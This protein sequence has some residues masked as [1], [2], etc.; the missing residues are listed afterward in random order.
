MSFTMKLRAFPAIIAAVLSASCSPSLTELAADFSAASGSLQSP[1]GAIL[2]AKGDSI[3]VQIAFGLADIEERSANTVATNF[4][5]ASVTKQFTAM[6]ILILRDRGSLRL[7]QPLADFFP[8]FAPIGREITI[9]Q[10]LTHT[11]GLVAYE[12]VMPD[13][14]TIPLLDR[15]VL[16]LVQGIHYLFT[17]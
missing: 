1:G 12:E 9:R 3:L 11:S 16:N 10:L 15:D 7:D 17:A 13:T 8:D 14:T 4:R 2:V 5:L 6:S